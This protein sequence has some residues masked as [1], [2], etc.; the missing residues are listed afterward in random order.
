MKFGRRFVF[1]FLLAAL[2][3][4][5]GW[6]VSR[7]EPVAAWIRL[8]TPESAQAGGTFPVRV[9]LSLNK[10]QRSTTPTFVG[11]HLHSRTKQGNWRGYLAGA[12]PQ[13]IEADHEVLEFNPTIPPD[14]TSGS[15]FVLA[16]ISPTRRWED[17]IA[18][19]ASDD[20]AVLTDTSA[21]S[22]ERLRSLPVRDSRTRL[23]RRRPDVTSV[24]W[25]LACGWLLAGGLCW[26]SPNTS[27]ASSGSRRL[28]PMLTTIAAAWEV[29]PF[30]TYLGERARTFAMTHDWYDMRRGPQEILTV[31]LAFGVAA[32]VL[33]LLRRGGSLKRQLPLLGFTLYVGVTLTG[34]LSLHRVD[35]ILRQSIFSVPLLQVLQLGALATALIGSA[36]PSRQY[37]ASSP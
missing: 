15:I 7:P 14:K 24:R 27:R 29:L 21:T 10:T 26:R 5:I 31:A 9:S 2:V 13:S 37:K 32:S 19:V 17:R 23:T 4:M 6:A 30:E 36:I 33:W 34:F 18:A 20:V 25:V 3:A 1:P 12:M 16:F 22:S 8:E 35:A 28:I 11:I